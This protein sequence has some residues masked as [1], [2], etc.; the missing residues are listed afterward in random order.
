MFRQPLVL[1]TEGPSGHRALALAVELATGDRG[2]L[3][4]ATVTDTSPPWWAGAGTGLDVA[5]EREASCRRHERLLAE[6]RDRLPRDLAVR[7]RCLQGPERCGA[8]VLRAL[9]EG[10]HDVLVV[11]A[12]SASPVPA[13]HG[14]AWLQRHSPVPVLTVR[15]PCR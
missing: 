1:V 10:G 4:L 11:E 2:C 12:P 13:G 14:S 7:T 3:T 9:A 8:Q 6:I 15:A 5:A